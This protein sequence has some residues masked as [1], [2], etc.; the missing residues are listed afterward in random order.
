[1]P[2]MLLYLFD[3][4]VQAGVTLYFTYWNVLI[5]VEAYMITENGCVT[6]PLWN[7]VGNLIIII[8]RDLII[9]IFTFL[10]VK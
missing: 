1:M 2:E 3:V 6:I 5:L 9:I 4:N 7:I 8:V 10:S